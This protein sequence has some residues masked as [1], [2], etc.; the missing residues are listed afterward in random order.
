METGNTS[1]AEAQVRQLLDTWTAAVRARD[2]EKVL[3]HHSADIVMFDVPPPVEW[4]GMRKY[5]ESWELFFKHFGG[6]FDIEKMD[7]AAS[8]D[9]ACGY[10]VLQCGKPGDT[11]PVRLTVCLRRIDGQWTIVHEHHSVPAAVED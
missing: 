4:R 2:I 6:A 5:R 7:I 8:G 1:A 3:A 9:V 10:G 11:F